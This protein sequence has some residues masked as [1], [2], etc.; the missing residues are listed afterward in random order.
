VINW[1]Y[2]FDTFNT[3]H[4]HGKAFIRACERGQLEFSQ[5]LYRIGTVD[6]HTNSEQAFRGA[7]QYGRLQVA[8]SMAIFVRECLDTSE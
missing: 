6:I 2:D 5:R 8:H 1:L 7:C 3:L 4:D